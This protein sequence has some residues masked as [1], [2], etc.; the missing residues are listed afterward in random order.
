VPLAAALLGR[1]AGD[2]VRPKTWAAMGVAV[3]GFAVMAGAPTRPGLAGTVFSLI[4]MLTFSATIVVARHKSDVSM[5]PATCLSQILV[6]AVFAPFARVSAMGGA[7]VVAPHRDGGQ[8]QFVPVLVDS[9]PDGPDLA[10]LRGWVLGQLH[11]PLTVADLAGQ[12][13]IRLRA[14]AADAEPSLHPPLGRHPAGLPPPFQ[15]AG[16]SQL[17]NR[18]AHGFWQLSLA[19]LH[20]PNRSFHLWP[21]IRVR[22]S[23]LTTLRRCVLFR[24]RWTCYLHLRRDRRA[25]R[26]SPKLPG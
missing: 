14:G 20:C 3:A 24:V 7:K 12:V 23:W 19:A 26:R 21:S 1:L 5:A 15:P 25:S 13:H 18:G 22:V 10:V 16:R 4:T 8:A 2:P 9:A 6:L 11:Q 17:T